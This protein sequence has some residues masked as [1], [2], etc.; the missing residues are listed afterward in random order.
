MAVPHSSEAPGSAR[1][2]WSASIDGVDPDLRLRRPPP[3]FRRGRVVAVERRTPRLVRLTIAGE[4]LVGFDAPEPAASLRLLL[5]RGGPGTSLEVPSWEGNEF[6]FADGTRPPIRTLTPLAPDAGRGRVDVEVVL[7]GDGALARWADAE[8]VG[9][10]VAISGPGRGYEVDPDLGRLLVAGDESA[11]PA[12][13]QLLD[14]LPTATEVTVIVE[15]DDH[16]ARPP[17]PER[18]GT[19][20]VWCDSM[21][22]AVAD[23]GIPV[24]T[25][26]WAAGEAAVVQRLRRLVADL[27]IPRADTTIRGYWKQGRTGAGS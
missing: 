3:A 19:E 22:D 7:H 26:V 8:P 6:L 12:I 14:R 18:P 10:E 5:P 1:T 24:G 4:E 2:P 21:V 25:Q 16:D 13:A 23:R 20:V 15:V 11:G 17:L 27:G 9:D